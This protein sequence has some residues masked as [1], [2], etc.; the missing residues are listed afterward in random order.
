MSKRRQPIDAAVGKRLAAARQTAGLTQ[1][2]LAQRSRLDQPSIS[3]IERGLQSLGAR[4]AK[5]LAT[6]L[7]IDPA[8]LLWGRQS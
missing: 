7:K 4:R 5:A 6:V 8:V 1:A 3:K 2:E